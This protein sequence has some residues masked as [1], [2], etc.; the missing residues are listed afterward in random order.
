MM[1]HEISLETDGGTGFH[2][3]HFLSS[4]GSGCHGALRMSVPNFDIAH[5]YKLLMV[6]LTAYY[7]H[8]GSRGEKPLIRNMHSA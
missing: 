2:K 3:T 5:I 6:G 7:P 1:C 8:A 4:L